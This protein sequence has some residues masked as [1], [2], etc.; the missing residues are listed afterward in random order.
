MGVPI[1]RK[2]EF[3]TWVSRLAFPISRL[4]WVSRLVPLTWVSLLVIPISYK[5]H[6]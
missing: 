1:S 4:T 6:R 2:Q 3:L 5:Y